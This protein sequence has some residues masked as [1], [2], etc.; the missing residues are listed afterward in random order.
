MSGVRLPRLLNSSM[1]EAQ[2]IQ[3]LDGSLSLNIVPLSTASLQVLTKDT[4]PTDSWIEMFS[5][6][7]SAG[8][9]RVS[10][11]NNGYG[12]EI[13][14]LELEHGIAEV[15]NYVVSAE[16]SAEMPLKSAISTLWGY[17]KGTRWKLGTNTFTDNVLVDVLYDN[18]LQAIL[19]VMDQT[20]GYMLDFDFSKSPWVMNIVRK[21][22][23]VS[24]EGRLSRNVE[25][26]SVSYDLTDLCTRVY[27]DYDSDDSSGGT[28]SVDADTISQF[29]LIEKHISGSGYTES[30]ARAAARD[31][32][33]KHKKPRASVTLTGRDLASITGESLDK[34]AVGKLY[35]LAIPKHNTYVEETITELR[36]PNLYT[37]PTK[38]EVTLGQEEDKVVSHL[39]ETTTTVSKSGKGTIKKQGRYWTKFDRTD[40]YIDQVA[41]YTDENGKILK[42]A[43]MYID[44]NGVLQYA[45]DNEKQI[46]SQF[47]VAADRIT[48]EVTQRENGERTLYSNIEQTATQIRTEVVNV[49]TGLESSISQTAEQIRGEV[50]D[51]AEELQASIDIQRDRIGLVVEGTGANAKIRPA[52]IVASINNASKT[53]SVL[54]SADRVKLSG[55]TTIDDVMTVANNYV[56]INSPLM[57]SSGDSG[58][59]LMY[60]NGVL[61]VK[62]IAANSVETPYHLTTRRALNVADAQVSGNTLTI[63]YVD[64]TTKTFSKATTLSVEY[65]GDNQG[66]TATYTVTASPQGLSAT[67]TFKVHQS[68]TAAYITDP[69]GTIRARINNP[70]YA[71]GWAAAYGKV[72]LPTSSSTAVSFSVQ[73]PPA[74]VDGTASTETYTMSSPMNNVAVVKNTAGTIVARLQHDKYDAGYVAGWNAARAKVTRSGN[75]IKR[76]KARTASDG[77]SARQVENEDAFT[78]TLNEGEAWGKADLYGKVESPGGTQDLGRLAY[79]GNEY[80][81]TSGNLT[82]KFRADEG[83]WGWST[84]PSI[85]WN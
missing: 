24:A 25:E 72:S 19:D 55:T 16:I 78:A 29:G 39:K 53:S 77:S 64:G 59:P 14:T 13:S 36:W 52:Q 12:S 9:Y 21:D 15:G 47:K 33:S 65:G 62:T 80:S 84:R 23:N 22:T 81:L 73:T 31:Y 32:L 42:Q 4:V 5:P 61:Y 1:A 38:V 26:A 49:K 28:L 8:I 71:N 27:V 58:S 54:I 68:K 43:G 17:Y 37:D 2:R 79:Y 7:G 66:D 75:T 50:S 48:A 56:H 44:A 40:H 11:A 82:Y 10:S 60:V 20:S 34:L 3:P 51:T 67:G 63:T 74:T 69:N 6:S 41:A 83:Y 30:Q 18:L 57:V 70:Q 76:P 45:Q 85:S 35:R 46:G